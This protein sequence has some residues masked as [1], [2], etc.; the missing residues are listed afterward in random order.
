MTS[1]M[2]TLIL[3]TFSFNAVNARA[4][5]E[6]SDPCMNC[7]KAMICSF[8][9]FMLQAISDP[10]CFLQ[11][12][13]NIKCW[14]FSLKAFRRPEKVCAARNQNLVNDRLGLPFRISVYIDSAKTHLFHS[15][16]PCTSLLSHQKVRWSTSAFQENWQKLLHIL[17]GKTVMIEWLR[18][19]SV[20]ERSEIREFRRRAAVH[21]K[22]VGG[23]DAA[24]RYRYL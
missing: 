7:F 2:S 17:I 16:R 8:R 3:A 12:L 21:R 24:P 19:G 11:S 20:L 18:K 1:F 4:S 14:V 10:A 9:R 15:V 22:R 6:Y 23:E 13:R 5:S